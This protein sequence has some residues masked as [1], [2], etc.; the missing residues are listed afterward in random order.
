MKQQQIIDK[1]AA[2]GKGILFFFL[3]AGMIIGILDYIAITGYGDDTIISIF[4]NVLA[5]K[6]LQGTVPF[7]YPAF[8]IIPISVIVWGLK[9]FVA[10]LISRVFLS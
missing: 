7:P 5:H 10:H 9:G 6:V 2:G 4:V 8:L 3:S 1:A